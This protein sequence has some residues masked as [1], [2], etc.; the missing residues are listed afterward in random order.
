MGRR[1][2]YLRSLQS[3]TH[4]LRDL[5]EVLG[6]PDDDVSWVEGPEHAPLL[7]VAPLDVGASFRERLWGREDSPTAVL[8]SATIP[9]RLGDRLG[10]PAGSFEILDV[11]PSASLDEVKEVYKSK[12]KQNHPDR[13]HG[14]SPAFRRLAETETKRLNAAYAEALATLRAE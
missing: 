4:L 7:R 3:A 12:I 6:L 10:L 5:D 2:R 1:A 9:P 8:T 14:M 11:A 13:V